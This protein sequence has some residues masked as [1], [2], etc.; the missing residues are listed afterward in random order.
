MSCRSCAERRKLIATAA[1]KEG[2]KGVAKALPAVF[3]SIVTRK[4]KPK[5]G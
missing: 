2:A 3:R 1:R 4:P 5:A